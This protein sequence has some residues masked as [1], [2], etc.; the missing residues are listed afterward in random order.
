MEDTGYVAT[1]ALKDFHPLIYGSSLHRF[2]EYQVHTTQLLS[3]KESSPLF[4]ATYHLKNNTNSPAVTVEIAQSCE[5]T[6]ENV[7][8][9][10][11]SRIN[12]DPTSWEWFAHYL[13]TARKSDFARAYREVANDIYNLAKDLEMSWNERGAEDAPKMFAALFEKIC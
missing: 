8:M 3:R 11:D 4:P 6:L 7:E 13:Y 2:G 5:T 12:W 1:S 10:K 9:L